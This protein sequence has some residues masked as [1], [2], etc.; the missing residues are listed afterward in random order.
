MNFLN[1]KG[2]L[3]LCKL[4]I[5][6]TQHL[7]KI[8]LS[9]C[10]LTTLPQFIKESKLCEFLDLEDNKLNED[11]TDFKG[12][13]NLLDLNLNKNKFT[14]VPPSIYDLKKL[15]SLAI[16]RQIKT[17]DHDIKNLKQLKEIHLG[18]NDNTLR[19]HYFLLKNLKDIR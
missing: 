4:E 19:K 18:W 17:I 2:N 13:T 1:L 8:I 12:L 15:K 9:K 5:N 11:S 6:S 7:K 16:S 10:C 14:T 3:D